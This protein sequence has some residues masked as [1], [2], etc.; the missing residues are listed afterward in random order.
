MRYIL[1]FWGIPMGLFWGWYFLSAA[2]F[3]YGMF[4]RHTHDFA[5]AFYGAIL[6]IDPATIPGMVARACVFDT[7][8]IF[9][10]VAFRRR[11]EILDWWHGRNGK[12]AEVAEAAQPTL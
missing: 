7:F 10:I 2:D 8:I 6:G 5:F 11:R 4:A 1:Y 12:S 3:G 9:G